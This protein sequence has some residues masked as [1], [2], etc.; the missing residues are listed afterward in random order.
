M[1]L[2]VKIA[3][4]LSDPA[5]RELL[6]TLSLFQLKK[7]GNATQT[8]YNLKEI[9]EVITP[10]YMDIFLASEADI[11]GAH[12]YSPIRLASFLDNDVPVGWPNSTITEGEEGEEV[13]RQKVVREYA[14][15][16]EV[17]GG[18]IILFSIGLSA[19]NNGQGLPTDAQL[20][21]GW[22]PA[23]NGSY[24]TKKQGRDLI[25]AFQAANQPVE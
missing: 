8:T 12:L 11:D 9:E 6:L 21:Q 10:T 18:W 2:S 22:L 13:T 1:L 17:E 20:R 19:Q 3:E 24:L 23:F 15:T 16:Y 7:R 4:V 25:S 14:P 5:L